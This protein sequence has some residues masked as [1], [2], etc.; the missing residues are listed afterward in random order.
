[1]KRLFYPPPIREFLMVFLLLLVGNLTAF[2]EGSKDFW[3]Y[4]GFR[5]FYL[6]A[7]ASATT[8][9]EQQLKVY[10][11]EGEYINVGS[12]HVG[13]AEGYIDV[14]GP[15]GTLHS[16]F[17]GS[18][19]AAIINSDV[20][21]LA[22]PTGAG[23][24]NGAG[25]IPGVT[26]VGPGQAGVW[27]VV[28]DYPE[29]LQVGGAFLN[30]SNGETWTREA[31][32]PTNGRV[33]L[34]WDITVSQNAAGNMGGNL[35]EGRVYSNEY[36]SIVS[37]PSGDNVINATSPTF[38]VLTRSGFQYKIDFNE[39]DPW[40]FP[41]FSNSMGIV[42]GDKKATYQSLD[43]ANYTRSTDPSSWTAA[44]NYLYHPQ[45]E[46]MG[47]LWN[48][49]IFF[50]IPD[51]SMPAQATVTDVI[52]GN[53]TH[54]TWLSN[55][56]SADNVG[57]NSFGF[58]GDNPTGGTAAAMMQVGEGG[59]FVYASQVGGIGKLQLDLNNNG[60]FDDAVDRVIEAEAVLGDNNAIFWDGI[61]GGGNAVPANPNFEFT[62]DLTVRGGEVHILMDD[63]ENN[64]GGVTFTRINGVNSPADEF[65]YD[66]SQVGG[67]VSGSGMDG[68]ALPT[69]IPFT[70]ENNFGNQKLLDYWAFVEAKNFGSGAIAIAVVQDLNAVELSGIDT[71]GD[72]VDDAID[73]DD[74]N[75]GI[76]DAD[77]IRVAV[78]GGDSDQDGVPDHFD[79][80]SDN[81]GL[82]D[83][84]EN[85]NPDPDGDGRIGMGAVTVNADGIVISDA[86]GNTIVYNPDFVDPDGPGRPDHIDIDSDNNGIFDVVEAGFPDPDNDGMFGTSPVA[87]DVNGCVIR[88]TGPPLSGIDTD[89][90]GIDD[91]ID[92]D[93]DNDGI[94]DADEIRVAVN[95]GDSDQDGVPDH[96]DRDSDN[97]GLKDAIENDNPDPDGDGIIGIGAP[98]VD[99]DGIVISD[100]A[101]NTIVYNP[102]FVDPDGPGR[103]DHIDIDSDNNGIFDVVEA[104]FPDPDNDG[105]F[106]TS[107]VQVDAFGC[108][109]REIADRDGDGIADDIDLDNDNDGISDAVEIASASS[110]NGDSDG[111]GILDQFDLDSDNDGISDLIEA[112][113]GQIDANGDGI[114]D[115]A[116]ADFGAN[117]L[118]NPLATSAD[119][120]DAEINYVTVDWDGDNVPDHLDLDSDNDG[121]YDVVE[122]SLGGSDTNNDGRIDTPVDANGITTIVNPVDTDGDGVGDWHDWDSDNDGIHDVV[123]NLN[124]DA[125]GDG[126]IGNGT[127]TVN[128][129]GVV[130][131]DATGGSITYN[132]TIVNTDGTGAAD[133][134]DLDSDGDGILDVAEAG[135]PDGDGDGILGTGIPTVN[136]FGVPSALDANG[137]TVTSISNP[138]DEDADG[139]P[140]FQQIGVDCTAANTP[141]LGAISA[142]DLCAGSSAVVSVSGA[143]NFAGPA[144]F[145]WSGPN[146]VVESGRIENVNSV[147][148]IT[149]TDAGTYS[150]SVTT[151]DGCTS[152]PVSAAVNPITGPTAVIGGT[153]GEIC[154][155]DNISLT[156]A[157]SIPIPSEIIPYASSRLEL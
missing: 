60:S 57:Q 118:Y 113:H 149:V 19:A 148:Q 79:L 43:R 140:D 126:I 20:E 24:S 120:L 48:N 28:L 13:I 61:D 133:Y 26:Q 71:D 29:A 84:I 67:A 115:G 32:Q 154:S 124:A 27:T 5:L 30:L 42:N 98:T 80:D 6:I 85:D 82:K 58:N 143:T 136:V 94:L 147:Y 125:D 119:G 69:S 103:P 9:N 151:D 44:N 34:A 142:G 137:N 132:P 100:A 112:G 56:V 95:G 16:T 135:L 150:L 2:G 21:E 88:D 134:R 87:V 68:N 31:N 49:K 7:D 64:L 52:N 51:V 128:A 144:N 123:E 17:D 91:A 127:P 146:G 37:N 104:G 76:L 102:D 117:G 72:G 15:D 14:Y 22:G 155:T 1:M 40:G 11:A 33:A 101:G 12:S 36:I 116:P 77:E 62:Y 131:I 47:L 139:T 70:Y 59:N 105:M 74:D 25:Y 109:V 141:V 53:N 63:V 83:A 111:D 107:P 89:G 96:L 35:I 86:A 3:D 46:D 50:N 97:D 145:T 90:D 114:I 4:P 23:T 73:L 55:A 122:V 39:S 138:R 106:G 81:D 18:T 152:A 108:V 8:T 92:L 75:D 110:A 38:Y 129:N 45:A 99:A 130:I 121:I 153:S 10:A 54:V 157:K 65:F 41:L 66:H 93:D 78:N 156:S